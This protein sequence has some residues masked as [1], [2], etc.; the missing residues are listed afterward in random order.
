MR[1]R[2]TSAR[3]GRDQVSPLCQF[4]GAYSPRQCEL[5][6]EMGCCPWE[7]S[8]QYDPDQEDEEDADTPALASGKETP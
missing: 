7:E 2:R 6:D 4:C 1:H 8:G 3:Q 5:E